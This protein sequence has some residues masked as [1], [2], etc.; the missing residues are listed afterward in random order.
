VLSLQTVNRTLPR[1]HIGP[2]AA[3]IHDEFVFRFTADFRFL[4]ARNAQL[5]IEALRGGPIRS[6]S[7]P[8]VRPCSIFFAGI[9]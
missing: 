4:A 9:P 2:E 5:Y 7:C 6:V 3:G 1:R 8:Q